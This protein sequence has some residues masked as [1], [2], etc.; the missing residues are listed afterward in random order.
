MTLWRILAVI[1]LLAGFAPPAQAQDQA[2]SAADRGAIRQ[3]I[4]DQVEA[5]RRDDDDAAFG[6]ASPTIQTMFG[7]SASF[8]AMVRRGYQPVYRPQSFDFREIVMLNGKPTQKVAVV[9]PDGR[10]VTAFYPMVQLPDGHWRI[11]G[12]YLSAPDDPQA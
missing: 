8:M 10:A 6:Y 1:G 3:T 2:L 7:T 4:Q 12:C 11:D 9:G 5:F